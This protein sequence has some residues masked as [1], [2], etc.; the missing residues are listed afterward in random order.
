MQSI[1][2]HLH[3]LRGRMQHVNNNLT[4]QHLYMNLHLSSL[5]RTLQKKLDGA[6]IQLSLDAAQFGGSI[7]DENCE[8]IWT[9]GLERECNLV[10]KR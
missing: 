5:Q 8:E 2:P 4:H 10:R 1:W 7:L 6:L 3:L 9:P